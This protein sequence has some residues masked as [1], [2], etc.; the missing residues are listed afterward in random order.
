MADKISYTEAFQIA[1]E[2][3]AKFPGIVAAQFGLET[4]WGTKTANAKNNLFNLKWHDAV[5][6]RM[7]KWGVEPKRAK[8][9]AKDKAT[10]SFDHYMEFDSIKDA[11]KGYLAFI[12]V[13]PR[14]SKALMAETPEEYIKELKAAGYAEDKN[15]ISKVLSIAK[16]IEGESSINK[17]N[18][19]DGTSMPGS[20]VKGVPGMD[21]IV[22]KAA[23][24]KDNIPTYV[25]KPEAIRSK[26]DSE[27]STVG[28]VDSELINKS[29]KNYLD[30][31]EREVDNDYIKMAVQMYNAT[32]LEEF[33]EDE[34][35]I[36]TPPEERV[37][38]TSTAEEISGKMKYGGYLQPNG[39]KSKFTREEDLKAQNNTLN[40]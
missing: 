16:P 20:N 31:P 39:N 4:A 28:D 8:K 1:K 7:T 40:E 33:A 35:Q 10:G 15:Y 9:G 30:D 21:E 2:A 29:I 37:I 17:N 5:A 38:P 24:V 11:F 14:Y 19:Q 27:Y 26:I 18:I 13:N 25:P 23:V 32:K 34:V 22:D 36:N 6:K 12:A 3:G